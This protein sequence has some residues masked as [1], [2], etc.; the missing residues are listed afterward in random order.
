[1]TDGPT[2]AADLDRTESSRQTVLAFVDDVL[3]HRQLTKLGDYVDPQ[4]YIEHDPE[5]ADGLERLLAALTRTGS[6]ASTQSYKTIHRVHHRH[7]P[8]S[9]RVEQQQRKI[10]VRPRLAT[11]PGQIF[12]RDS[13]GARS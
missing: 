4:S 13:H 1:M 5:R 6:E 8:A 3:I 7:H 12:V 9:T 2:D 10:L 11:P